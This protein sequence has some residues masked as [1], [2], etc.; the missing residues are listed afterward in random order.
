M[1]TLKKIW[2]LLT[3]SEQRKAGFLVIIVIIMSF[4]EVVGVASVLPFLGVLANPDLVHTNELLDLLNNFLGLDN[5]D[6]FLYFLGISAFVLLIL[7]AIVRSL[8]LYAVIRFAQMRRHSMGSRLLEYHL[9]QPYEFFI[10]RHSG[11]LAKGILSEVDQVVTGVFQPAATMV[12]QLFT[13]IALI[14]L[15]VIVDPLVALLTGISLGVLYGIIY[16]IIRIFLTKIGKGQVE[17]NKQRFEATSE[18]LGGIKLIKLMGR[19]NFYLQRFWNPSYDMSHYISINQVLSLLPKFSIEALAFGAILFLSLFLM[20]KYGGHEANALDQVL[21][22]L[23]LYAFAGYRLLPAIQAIYSALTQIRFWTPAIESVHSDLCKID[24]DLPQLEKKKVE[25]LNFRKKISLESL[26]YI[27]PNSEAGGVDDI[28]LDIPFGNSIGIAGT[29]GSGKTTLADL[30]LGLLRP[31]SGSLKV[32]GIEIN[33]GNLRNWQA[34]IGYVPQDIFLIDASVEANIA[35]GI[36]EKEIDKEQVKKC[37][38]YAA[39]RSYIEKELPMGF[40]SKVGERGVRLSGGQRQRIGIARALYHNPDFIVFDEATS[41]L[42]NKTE[43]EVMDA[44]ENLSGHKTLILIAHR[45]TTLELCDQIVVLDKGKIA[46]L[47]TYEYL[48]KNNPYFQGL[49][50]KKKISIPKKN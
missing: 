4:F 28:S 3:P 12:A 13:L 24:A 30:M 46:G 21:P 34:N 18:V 29:T 9:R 43:K 22:L 17:R 27:Y 48:S 5:V 44:L 8:G 39:I 45:L 41:A 40:N 32:D 33:D 2:A 38:Q 47:G 49:K 23:G 50:S 37:A 42:D 14:L 25:V 7:A 36:P 35:M 26:S 15:L 20:Y 1:G 10:G 16:L 11:D 31:S 19:E 6:Q